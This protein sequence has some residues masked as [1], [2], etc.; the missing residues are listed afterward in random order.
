MT[1]VVGRKRCRKRQN[2]ATEAARHVR[3]NCRMPQ[4]SL[5]ILAGAGTHAIVEG[6]ST[7]AMVKGS[8]TQT[9]VEGSSTAHIGRQMWALWTQAIVECNSTAYTTRQVRARWL[10][11]AAQPH[12]ARQVRHSGTHALMQWQKVTALRQ[13]SKVA[14]QPTPPGKG[15]HSG[16]HAKA[17][18]HSTAY[19]SRQVRALRH[20]V[21]GGKQQHSCNGWS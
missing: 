4:H 19:T 15:G 10:H 3:Y 12:T 17:E 8:N 1:A 11:V 13:L 6:S 16:T 5:H 2:S 21:N 20:S 14:A 7:Q 18:G 9:I